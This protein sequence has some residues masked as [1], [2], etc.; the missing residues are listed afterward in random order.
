MDVIPDHEDDMSQFGK[1]RS[2]VSNIKDRDG[3]CHDGATD[4]AAVATVPLSYMRYRQCVQS[5]STSGG[6]EIE[7]VESRGCGVL[8]IIGG[9][10]WQGSLVLCAYLL[11]RVP[12]CRLLQADVLELGSGVGLPA[13]LLI[14]LK[15]LFS[16]VMQDNDN[17]GE[18]DEK[19]DVRSEHMNSMCL[20]R[21]ILSDNDSRVID[22]LRSAVSKQFEEQHCDSSDSDVGDTRGDDRGD[23]D[24][25]DD[26]VDVV[27]SSIRSSYVPVAIHRLDWRH[28]MEVEYT[29]P[30]S[31][32]LNDSNRLHFNGDE[33]GAHAKHRVIIGSELCYSKSHATYLARLIKSHLL[34]PRKQLRY[35]EVVICQVRDREG[36][37]ELLALLDDDGDKDDDELSGKLSY[38]VEEVPEAV[39]AV[40]QRIEKKAHAYSSCINDDEGNNRSI[41]RFPVAI[42]QGI[43][44]GISCAYDESSVVPHQGIDPEATSYT[45]SLQKC[46]IHHLLEMDESHH[47]R[48]FRSHLISTD[49]NAFVILRIK[50]VHL[51]SPTI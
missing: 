27:N 24:N 25:D 34:C 20:S 14:A 49:I 29:H 36:F 16:T 19:K 38:I 42:L 12:R 22:N 48:D 9:E 3:S 37:A 31:K 18:D 35:D 10:L 8:D 5:L 21:V 2:H 32:S 41:Y 7:I 26:D 46:S 15:S 30:Q 17:E 45:S 39:F 50:A 4:A 1:I 44:Q 13:M 40:G 6:I 51:S 28:C 23:D 33:D 11:M 47:C 43:S